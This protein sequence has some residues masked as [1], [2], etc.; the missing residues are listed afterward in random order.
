VKRKGEKQKKEEGPNKTIMSN[1]ISRK[2]KNIILR[3]TQWT[4]TCIRTSIKSTRG[5]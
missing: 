4:I 2:L 3:I 5:L 1:L